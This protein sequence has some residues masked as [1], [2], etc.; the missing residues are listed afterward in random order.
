[1]DSLPQASTA[2]QVRAITP[3]LP[4]QFVKF[5]PLSSVKVIAIASVAEQLSVAVALPPATLGSMP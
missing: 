5:A 1:M 3:A 4:P 2:F